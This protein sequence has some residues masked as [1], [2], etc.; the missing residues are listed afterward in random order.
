MYYDVASFKK[1]IVMQ[2]TFLGLIAVLL[3]CSCKPG[4]DNEKLVDSATGEKVVAVRIDTTARLKWYE[5]RRFGFKVQLPE[6]WLVVEKH[7]ATG[8]SINLLP[9]GQIDEN[10]LPLNVHA[11][12]GV[13]YIAVWPGGFGTELPESTTKTFAEQ[14]P[15]LSFSFTPNQASSRSFYL[16]NGSA[17][18]YFIVPE[19]VPPHWKYGFVFAQTGVK[20]HKETCYDAQSG[21]PKNP[22]QCDGLNGDSIV[23]EGSLK[24]PDATNIQRVLMSLRFVAP[25]VDTIEKLIIIDQPKPNRVIQSPVEV[26]GKARGYW[27]FEA[28]FPVYVY[29]ANNKE[30]GRGIAQADGNWMTQDFVPFHVSLSLQPTKTK[31]GR[32]VFVKSNPSGLS[33]HDQQYS[34]PVRFY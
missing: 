27:F 28:S 34:I 6:N 1:K 30:I 22:E 31:M 7:S 9:P 2:S 33:K 8:S 23:R 3:T 20:Q 14:Q 4:T 18:G 10:E 5:N 32:L 13:T 17:W 19:Q 15:D 29:D 11:D 26:R 12:P 16:K 25:Q 24:Q 21:Q